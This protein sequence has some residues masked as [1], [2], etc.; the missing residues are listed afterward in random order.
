MV[1]PPLHN[2]YLTLPVLLM[3]IGNHYAF[4]TDNPRAWLLVGLV[5]IG[6]VALGGGCELSLGAHYRVLADTPRAMMGLPECQVGLLPGAG[7]TQRMP[8]LVGV[9]QGLQVLVQARTYSGQ[10]AID[11]GLVHAL[12]PAG[13]EVAAAEAWLLSNHAHAIQ[14]WD[15]DDRQPLVHA[16]YAGTLATH[17]DRELV[18]MLGHEPAPLAILDCLELGL[19]QPMDGAIRSEMSVFAALIQRPEPRNMIRTLFLGKQ[20]YDKA[21]EDDLH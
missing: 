20:A 17:R 16:D 11:A 8:R 13:E 2:T 4:V 12:V 1:V 15:R 6:G 5:V 19:M 9:E 3:M 21:V 14:P 7:G 18:R 10:Q